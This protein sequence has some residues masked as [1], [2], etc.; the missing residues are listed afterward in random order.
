MIKWTH[1]HSSIFYSSKFSKSDLS[2][3]FTV[4]ILCHTVAITVYCLFIC[5][6]KVSHFLRITWQLRNCFGK[7]LWHG[8]LNIALYKY[9]QQPW[10]NSPEACRL[11]W[12]LRCN[13]SKLSMNQRYIVAPELITLHFYLIPTRCMHVNTMKAVN[14]EIFQGMEVEMFNSE[15]F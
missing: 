11:L 1:W 14:C 15:T 8:V 12:Y 13:Y 7:F 5:S 9:W 2:K 6:E 4:K 3:F 10:R